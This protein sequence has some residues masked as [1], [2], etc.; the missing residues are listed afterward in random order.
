[1]VEG[2]CMAFDEGPNIRVT[3]GCRHEM[4]PPAYRG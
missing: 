3:A 1:V 2:L 4:R